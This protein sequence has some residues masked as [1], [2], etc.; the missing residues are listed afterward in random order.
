MKHHTGNGR[1]AITL[2]SSLLCAQMRY[3]PVNVSQDL[4]LA[5]VKIQHLQSVF[6]MRIILKQF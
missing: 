3:Q 4:K 5:S 6:V 2:R 1:K